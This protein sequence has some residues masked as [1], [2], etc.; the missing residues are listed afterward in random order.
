MAESSYKVTFLF[1]LSKLIVRVAWLELQL[2]PFF[3]FGALIGRK[4]SLSSHDIKTALISRREVEG[5]VLQPEMIRQAIER[6]S[7]AQPCFYCC[8]CTVK[9]KKKNQHNVGHLDVKNSCR[10][11]RASHLMPFLHWTNVISGTTLLRHLDNEQQRDFTLPESQEFFFFFF[12]KQPVTW[13]RRTGT[14]VN[15]HNSHKQRKCRMVVRI[16]KTRGAVGFRAFFG[17]KL[18]NQTTLKCSDPVQT[19]WL[20]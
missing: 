10:E 8:F 4:I 1:L 18:E 13:G 7:A 15:E 5:V 2:S 17:G 20:W 12:F 3:I 11:D 19:D 9:K 16:G 6:W 14:Q